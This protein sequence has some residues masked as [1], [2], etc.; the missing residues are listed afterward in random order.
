MGVTFDKAC[1]RMK[2]EYLEVKVLDTKVE[3]TRLKVEVPTSYIRY[4]GNIL[5]WL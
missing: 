1:M 2:C 5:E 3:M 4:E